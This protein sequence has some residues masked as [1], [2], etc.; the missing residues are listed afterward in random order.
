MDTF[1]AVV[2]KAPDHGL[3]RLDVVLDDQN[4][5]IGPSDRQRLTPIRCPSLPL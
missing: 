2:A 4:T 1:V 5:H 3:G